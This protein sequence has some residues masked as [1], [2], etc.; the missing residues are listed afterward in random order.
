MS[1]QK[2]AQILNETE[3][4]AKK[5]G[6]GAADVLSNITGEIKQGITGK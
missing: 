3:R 5:V 4:T 1:D 6:T 2:L